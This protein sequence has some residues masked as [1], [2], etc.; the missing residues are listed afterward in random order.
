MIS[1]SRGRALRVRMDTGYNATGTRYGKGMIQLI[2]YRE[3]LMSAE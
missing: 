1:S 3:S 2:R